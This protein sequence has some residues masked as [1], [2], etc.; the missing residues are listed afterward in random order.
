[1]KDVVTR[2]YNVKA[3]IFFSVML[4]YAP[5]YLLDYA[6]NDDYALIGQVLAG[7]CDT[8][9]WD[10]MSGRPLFGILRLLAYKAQ[11]SLPELAYLRLFSALCAAGLAVHLFIFMRRCA[12]L[13]DDFK[14]AL[15][16]VSICVIPTFQVYTSWATCSVYILATWISLAS[17]DVLI[18]NKINRNARFFLSFLLISSSFA[19]YQPAGMAVLS[20][21]FLHLCLSD[22][23]VKLR[24]I[25][26]PFFLA[27]SGVVS[28]AIM[29]KVIPQLM[30]GETFQRAAITHDV[31]GKVKW[32]LSEPLRIAVSNYDITLSITYLIA[33][34]ILTVAGLFYIYKIECGKFKLLLAA[35]F[36]VGSFSLSLIVSESWATWRTLTG[37]SIVITSIF[38]C[39]I[40][41]LNDRFLKSSPTL[42]LT[43]VAMMV[44]SCSFNIVRG[45]VI[46]QRSELQS[47]AAELSNKVGKQYSG[48]IMIDL[49]DQTY[50]AF[51]TVQRTD[52]FGNISL[53]NEWAP[54]GM[55]LYL[56]GTK[57]FSY[58]IPYKP[59]I[60]GKDDCKSNCIAISTGPAMMKSVT[61]F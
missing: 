9:K 57:G 30:Y 46:P 43:L 41:Y 60:L 48:K 28:S 53:A 21:A 52:E 42:M 14:R 49:K 4:A 12:T 25:I 58:E 59:T 29:T 33:S 17:Y 7:F 34:T 16:S 56:K 50:N 26:P 15:L 19:I 47:L 55:A 10:V 2:P 6:F 1:M 35:A 20:F 22:S 44:T 8:F 18:N 36:A 11:V 3:I 5:A 45:F 37:L 24:N 32:F 40:F 31:V 23:A 39:G 13:G 51:S 54:W 38:M 61:W 27:A